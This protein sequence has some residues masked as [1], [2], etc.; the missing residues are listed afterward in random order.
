[1]NTLYNKKVLKELTLYIFD[2]Y[3]TIAVCKSKQKDYLDVHILCN[4]FQKDELNTLHLQEP[5]EY[6]DEIDELYLT[7]ELMS[8]VLWHKFYGYKDKSYTFSITSE[9]DLDFKEDLA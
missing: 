2:D 9:V 6:L 7:K 5:V 1:M 8:F 4:Y 3:Y